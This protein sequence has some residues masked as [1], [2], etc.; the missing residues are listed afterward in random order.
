M[1]EDDEHDPTARR[2]AEA[3]QAPL[4]DDAPPPGSRLG[5]LGRRL[6]VRGEDVKELASTLLETSDRAKSEMVRMVA[7]EVRN[8]LDEL[9]LKEDVLE[10]VRSHSLEINMS[11]HLKPLADA[12][13]KPAPTKEPA[14]A[15]A[16]GEASPKKTDGGDPPT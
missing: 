13:D 4:G 11:I 3:S 1:A 12:I 9:K 6:L 2:R 5:R 16:A 10:L 14:A 8:Y 15:D 7:R